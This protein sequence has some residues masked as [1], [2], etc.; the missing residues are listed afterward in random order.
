MTRSSDTPDAGTLDPSFAE[1]GVLRLPTPEFT[2]YYVQTILPL[3]GKELL[4]GMRVVGEFEPI[5]LAKL[6]EDGSVDMAFGGAGTGLVEFYIKGERLYVDQLC[7]LSDGGWLVIGTYQSLGLGYG[8]K[9][10]LRYFQDG[11]LDR[12]F[13]ENGLRLLPVKEEQKGVEKK[14]R[15][16]GWGDGQ[17]SAHGPRAQGR[18]GAAA[19]Q[20]LDGKIVLVSYKYPESGPAQRIVLRL[21]P[22]GS[23]DKTFNGAG[24][25]VIELKDIPY[26]Y[27][28]ADA[29]AVQADGKVVVAGT[30]SQD[31]PASR[32]A[33]VT[34]FDAMGRLDTSFNGGV[35]T[36]P[37]SELIYVESMAVRQN[38]GAVVVIGEADVDRVSHGLMFVLTSGGF[39]DFHFNRGQPLFSAPLP[40]GQNWLH[41]ALQADGSILV[42]GTTGGAFIEKGTTAL[43]ARFHSDG[44][45]DLAFNRRGFAVFDD[46][47]KYR[48]VEAMAVMTDG[49]I[50][51]GGFAW[52]DGVDWPYIDSG[53]IIRYQA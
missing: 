28:N 24:F 45:L 25:A 48:T 41:C 16:S 17:F 30:Y 23:M 5:G 34:R 13:G 37:H 11:Q 51:V 1:G 18:Q 49:R 43:T 9:Y 14:L 8:G 52:E 39:F 46:A 31:S 38:D 12:S 3:A 40:Q 44:S 15:V 19:V 6:N 53:W 42:T 47:G 35:V 32:G 22:D 33:Y 2:G 29:V 7:G 50:V 27:L 20:Q 36:V 26:D 21:N 10:L 4:F